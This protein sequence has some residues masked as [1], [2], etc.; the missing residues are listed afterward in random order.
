MSS[1]IFVQDT[2]K[3]LKDILQ[4][5]SG[6]KFITGTLDPSAVA[7]DAPKGSFY[8]KTDTPA[9]YIKIDNGLTIG[10]TLQNNHETLS[11]LTGGS[12]SNHFHI[13]VINSV[14]NLTAI[15]TMSV[16]SV[17]FVED[18]RDFFAYELNPGLTVDGIFVIATNAGGTTRWVSKTWQLIPGSVD[19]S[20]VATSAPIG[21]VYINSTTGSRYIKLDAGSTTNWK[22]IITSAE[23]ETL[24][25]PIISAV[26]PGSPSTG[27]LWMTDVLNVK[28][29]GGTLQVGEEMYTDVIN[30]T[31]S[32]LADGRLIY[33]SGNDSGHPKAVLAQA[34]TLISHSTIAMTTNA[35]P[36]NGVSNVTTMGIVHELNTLLDS[37]GNALTA[38]QVLY[39]SSTVPGGYTRIEPLAPNFSIIIGSV[40]V[41]DATVGKIL[42][43][44][45]INSARDVAVITKD[46]TG[47]DNP[48]N[49]I[50]TY[51]PTTQKLTLTGTFVAYWRGA[52]VTKIFSGLVSAAH[53]NS[54]GHVYYYSF[55]GTNL[56]WIQDTSWTFDQLMI[57]TVQYGA[58]DKFA[59]RECHGLMDYRAHREFHKVIGT[60]R[61]SGGTLSDYTLASTTAADRRP[62]I[63]ACTIYDEDLQ[64]INPAL[65]SKSY[66]IAHLSGVIATPTIVFT[67]AYAEMIHLFAATRPGYNLVSGG[68]WTEAGMVDKSYQAIWLFA[69]PATA[70]AGSQ[71]FRFVWLMGQSVN[72]TLSTIQALT[73][74]DLTLGNLASLSEEYVFITKVILRYDSGGGGTWQITQVN[75]LTGNKFIQTSTAA[76]IYLSAVEHD[77][78]LTG[79]GSPTTP[80]ATAYPVGVAADWDVGTDPVTPNSALDKIASQG[81]VKVQTMNTVFA[82]PTAGANALPTFRALVGADIPLATNLLPG[83]LSA[84]SFNKYNAELINYVPNGNFGE[85]TTGWTA[86]T[87]TIAVTTGAGLLFGVNSALIDCKTGGTVVANLSTIDS[88]AIGKVLYFVIYTR[89]VTTYTS[90]DATIEI[91]DVTNSLTVAGTLTN[92]LAGD[93][94]VS[95]TFLPAAATQ[96]AIKIT[97]GN[98]DG[99]TFSIDNASV[100][101]NK[102]VFSSTTTAV[103]SIV[104]YTAPTQNIGNLATIVNYST[105]VFD[106]NAEVTTGATW[107]FTAKKTGYYK[108]YSTLLLDSAAG[109]E[110]NEQFGLG[111]YVS[112]TLKQTMGSFLP[113]A[114]TAYVTAQI[115]GVVYLTAGQYIDVRAN[116]SANGTT[117]ALLAAEAYNYI[118]IEEIQSPYET[119][120]PISARN[121]FG[122]PTGALIP[123]GFIGETKTANPDTMILT[124]AFTQV[125]S[126]AITS[127]T[128]GTYLFTYSLG[129]S[130]TNDATASAKGHAVFEITDSAGTL[131]GSSTKI[132]T[133]YGA[134][135]VDYSTLNHSEVIRVTATTSFEIRAKRILITGTS[136][137]Y[138]YTDANVLNVFQIVRLG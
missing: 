53:T 62:Q 20:S 71:L 87:A 110:V 27:Q 5:K 77:T 132:H 112:G 61:S 100:S 14:A 92:I 68:S 33:T 134:S 75:D 83:G 103:K 79:D 128:P 63:S 23:G 125:T 116:Q 36:I 109:W 66:T 107:K 81:I 119:I 93:N 76:G 108:V 120:G 46:P 91:Y 96:Y 43:A 6:T 54:T 73:P 88:G 29:P 38:G 44:I 115:S 3:I 19:P 12:V 25:A 78:S 136:V 135:I 30:K 37:E 130:I 49:V 117:L 99:H 105:L 28:V 121:V 59:L 114:A 2:V 98:H 122:D 123:A 131:V 67:T 58:T 104:N 45:Q 129:L 82:G 113:V 86:T 47:F 84:R 9:F 126:S 8:F 18:L 72:L 57:A 97:T 118:T 51:D 16:D 133:T 94:A 15:S 48:E 74:A 124:D 60:Y 40:L 80:L 34:N 137:V 64:T 41:V 111:I 32:I 69:M 4:Y 89:G 138:A 127:V 26:V 55:D 56:V 11:G 13:G 70:S 101:L 35:I 22:K 21:A 90:A 1:S 102:V 85:G 17:F 42:V 10:W 65:T 52:I 39:L 7:V 106:T 31:G 95:V 50:I 24:N